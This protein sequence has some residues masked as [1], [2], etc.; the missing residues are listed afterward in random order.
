MTEIQSTVV[1]IACW[2][3]AAAYFSLIPRCHVRARA[4]WANSNSIW[5]HLLGF[6]HAI[7]HIAC[8]VLISAVALQAFPVASLAPWLPRVAGNDYWLSLLITRSDG[9]ELPA[10]LALAAALTIIVSRRLTLRSLRADVVEP[11][12]HERNLLRLQA[13]VGELPSPMA[14]ESQ[15]A[16]V[17]QAR[18]RAPGR[19]WGKS[20]LTAAL[21]ALWGL[22]LPIPI[23]YPQGAG[24]AQKLSN[25]LPAGAAIKSSTEA[26]PPPQGASDAYAAADEGAKT[27][28]A[29]NAAAPV[30]A[31][32]PMQRSENEA[33]AA[34]GPQWRLLDRRLDADASRLEADYQTLR[35]C[36]EGKK[37][38]DNPK[39]RKYASEAILFARVQELI[40]SGSIAQAREI[41]FMLADRGSSRAALVLGSTFDALSLRQRGLDPTVGDVGQARFWYRRAHELELPNGVGK[42]SR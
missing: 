16:V 8:A 19:A 11:Q 42:Y 21:V 34:A 7:R 2:V 4:D 32:A 17:M 26:E 20:S 15:I 25:E 18:S 5:R 10:V 38:G 12:A 40:A 39:C 9:S 1:V 41:L 30:R 29:A 24:L 6:N 13:S 36:L 33:P 3:I 23:G 22:C 28:N 27:N 14:G 31:L 37:L 35:G